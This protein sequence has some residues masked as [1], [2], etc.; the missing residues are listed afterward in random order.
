MDRYE[1]MYSTARR[2]IVVGKGYELEMDNG[3]TRAW[4]MVLRSLLDKVV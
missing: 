4:A 1:T 3:K 2:F